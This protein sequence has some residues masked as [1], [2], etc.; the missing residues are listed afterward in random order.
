[1]SFRVLSLA[2]AIAITLMLS[3]A[4]RIEAQIVNFRLATTDLSGTPI[5]SVNVGDQ[6]L[7][8]TYTQHVGGYAGAPDKGGVFAAYLDIAYEAS[9]ASV[10]DP[11]INHGP[12]YLNGKSGD[13][14]N[15]GIMDNIGG[16]SSNGEMGIGLE[17]L[18][19]D[20]QF[21]FSLLMAADAPGEVT[22]VGS[23][24]LEYP[25]YEVLVYGLDTPISPL[26]IDFGDADLRMLFGS[27]SLSV[28]AVPEP[29][30]SFLLLMGSGL[31][32]LRRRR[33]P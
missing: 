28:N 20:E 32:A 26:D 3:S 30:G 10:A 9:L 31:I 17:P 23:K 5:E 22:F 27:A 13:L 15:G 21:V 14:S 2:A 7:L 4:G 12:L 33:N 29:G 1:M 19:A 24:A 25:A 6:F 8:Q 18:G 16:F 11:T